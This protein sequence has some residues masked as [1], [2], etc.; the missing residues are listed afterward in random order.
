MMSEILFL[1]HRIPFPADRGDK[2]RSHHILKKLATMAPVHVATF[3]DDALD[4]AEEVELMSLAASY[5]L[6]RR[7]KP[8][9]LA[10]LQALL[11]RKP[12][13]LTAFHDPAIADYVAA[14]LAARNIAAIYVFSGQMGQYV[15]EDFH[16]R[17]IVDFVDVDSAKFDA[18][19]QTAGW[20]PMR[21][22]NAARGAAAACCNEEARL[23]AR[24]EVSLLISSPRSRPVQRST[25]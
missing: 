17:V 25:A 5:R 15:P 23:A 12:V 3:A 22:V 9:L 7:S 19:A 24:A 11:T 1:S 21:S 20:L 18:Y 8:L 10:G 14:T 13:S 4:A 6:V 2:I 16:G